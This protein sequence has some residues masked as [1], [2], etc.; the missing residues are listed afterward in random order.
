MKL[1][2]IS[3]LEKDYL[4]GEIKV[5]ALQGVTLDITKGDFI[6][7]LGP[8]GCGKS[9]FLNLI[10]AIDKPS[11]GEI[12][13]NINPNPIFL[14]KLKE[15]ELSKY[16][17]KYI[18]FVFQFYNLVPSLTAIENIELAARL[19]SSGADSKDLASKLIED[20]GLGDKRNKYPSQLSGGEQ[21][22]VSI[23]RA[24]AKKPIILLADEPTGAID[25]QTTGKLMILLKKINKEYKT[26]ILIGTHNIGISY[27]ANKVIYLKDGKIFGSSDYDSEKEKIFWKQI[28]AVPAQNNQNI[29]INKDF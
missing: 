10:G 5:P 27:L 2:E 28:E 15:V 3:N 8:S 29:V 21:Q 23:A 4:T 18:G 13:I 22:R 24:L 7:I 25:S 20:V 1:I 9:T 17:R 26:T 14:S 19:T 12:K 16:R 11:G 6:T